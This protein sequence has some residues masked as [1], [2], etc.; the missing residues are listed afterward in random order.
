MEEYYR[1]EELWEVNNFP[2][3]ADLETL[4]R[5]TRVAPDRYTYRKRMLYNEEYVELYEYVGDDLNE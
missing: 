4:D 2:L 1:L 5:L 3:S